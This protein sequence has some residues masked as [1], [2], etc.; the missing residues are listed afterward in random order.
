[1]VKVEKRNSIDLVRA[2]NECELPDAFIVEFEYHSTCSLRN[3]INHHISHG[4]VA[5]DKKFSCYEDKEL[6]RT[7]VT[8][9]R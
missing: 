9:V 3:L 7:V 6:E 5:G 1:M 8:R 2:L 4:K